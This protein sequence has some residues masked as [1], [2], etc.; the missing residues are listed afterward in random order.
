M[1]LKFSACNYLEVNICLKFV[2]F[3]ISL[4]GFSRWMLLV[5][6]L[7]AFW[8]DFMNIVFFSKK[9]NYELCFS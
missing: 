3:V 2:K 9:K 7:L 5:I 1:G 4:A 6:Y 8:N